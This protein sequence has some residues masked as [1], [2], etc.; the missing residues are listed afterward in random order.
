MLQRCPDCSAKLDDHSYARFAVT[1]ASDENNERLA[2][3]C[4]ALKTHDWMV[5]KSFQDF[6]P[7][8]NALEAIVLRC[9]S[10]VMVMLAVRNP[11]ELHA[12]LVVLNCD[13]LNADTGY[14]LQSIIE[15]DSWRPLFSTI[16]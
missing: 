13:V 1:V 6:D 8:L 16:A 4:G 5:V 3:F 10:G 7:L 11:F 9:A 15:P 2:T 14:A 12:S